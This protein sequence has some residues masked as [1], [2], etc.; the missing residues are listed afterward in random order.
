MLIP[1]VLMF[2]I[3]YFVLIRPQRKRQKELQAQIEALRT[4][5]RI[6]TIGGMH[7]L[8]TNVKERTIVLKV[9]DNTKVEFEKSAVQTV[10]RKKD[11]GKAD[12]EAEAESTDA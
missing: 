8:V 9:A 7:G 6:I 3:M 11:D 4:G 2:V 5:D 12:S 1:F 10:V